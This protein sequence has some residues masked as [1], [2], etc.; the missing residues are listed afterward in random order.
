VRAGQAPIT[1]SITVRLV[2]KWTN[3]AA[4]LERN[5]VARARTVIESVVVMTDLEEGTSLRLDFN[6]LDDVSGVVPC[7]VQHADNGDVILVAFVNEDALVRSLATGSA[8]FWST[9]RNELWE[10]GATSGETFELVEVRVNCEQNSLLCRVRPRRGGICHTRNVG[11]A[12]RDGFYRRLDFDDRTLQN[13]DARPVR[14]HQPSSR[15]PRCR[16]GEPHRRTARRRAGPTALVPH[17]AGRA[18]KGG[19]VDELD[20]A[21]ILDPRR[22]PA[23]WARRSQ[24]EGL[25]MDPHRAA[26]VIHGPEDRH[27]TESDEQLADA[28]RVDFHRG[29]RICWRREPPDSQGPCAAPGTLSP[30][31]DPKSRWCPR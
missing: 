19:E 3:L 10:K 14:H 16:L 23:P 31:S 25:D 2:D 12:A 29:S 8:V 9:S 13:L 22:P 11:G 7:A 28:R 20:L 27:V 17:Q 26:R 21:P 15:D 6:K 30:P 1:R 5:P 18:T 24:A 4:R